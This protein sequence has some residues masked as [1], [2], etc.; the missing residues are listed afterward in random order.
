MVCD[1]D[2]DD[3]DDDDPS[4]STGFSQES[5]YQIS[6]KKWSQ[7]RSI[8]DGPAAMTQVCRLAIVL[9]LDDLEKII[10]VETFGKDY[11]VP[12][13]LHQLKMEWKK[14]WRK[15]DVEP[16]FNHS[17]WDVS[18]KTGKPEIFPINNWR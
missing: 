8:S 6:W 12:L 3:D 13:H 1:D 17:W 15:M 4:Y 10:G 14:P 16:G 2:D 11:Q 18:K 7:V 5:L 9:T